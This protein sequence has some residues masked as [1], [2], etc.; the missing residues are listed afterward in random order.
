MLALTMQ[1]I[2]T[3]KQNPFIQPVIISGEVH[4]QLWE[5]S[6]YKTTHT[7][8]VPPFY[9]GKGRELSGDVEVPAFGLM[10]RRVLERDGAIQVEEFDLD[11]LSSQS[12]ELSYL[13]SLL[14]RV[15]LSSLAHI[16]SLVEL[17]TRTWARNKWRSPFGKV[18]QYILKKRS[19]G[20][21][22]DG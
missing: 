13:V 11:A 19:R 21:V 7:V 20:G 10:V 4:K 1:I 2:R 12:Y 16:K 14:R 5:F 8:Y 17:E 9:D 3:T 18:A 6:I 15:P 22:L